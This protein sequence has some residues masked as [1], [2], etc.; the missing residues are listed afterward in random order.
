[1]KRDYF[2]PRIKHCPRCKGTRLR[3][4][5]YRERYGWQCRDCHYWWITEQ[6]WKNR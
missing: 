2:R 6:E 1:M 4:F 5:P 3:K